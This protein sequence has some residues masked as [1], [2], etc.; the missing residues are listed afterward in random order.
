VYLIELGTELREKGLTP[1]QAAEHLLATNRWA[2]W[3]DRERLV[4]TFASVYES[5]GDPPTFAD[6]MA[7]LTAMAEFHYSHPPKKEE[8]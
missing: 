2:D 8:A 6:S 7:G 3:G 1:W 4:V 5:L